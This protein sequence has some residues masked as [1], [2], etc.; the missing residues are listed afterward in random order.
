MSTYTRVNWDDLTDAN[1]P[2]PPGY[3]HPWATYVPYVSRVV[4]GRLACEHLAMS[5]NRME[6]GTSG[7]HHTHPEAEEIFVVMDGSCQ[8]RIDDE[9]VELRLNEA[10]RVPAE[11]RRSMHNPGP[12]ECWMLVIGAPL[13]EFTEEMLPAYFAANELDDE[14]A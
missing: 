2:P 3:Q 6:P 10:V 7:E 1:V 14:P 12:D 13:T 4:S 9:D 11:V 8:M 5:V